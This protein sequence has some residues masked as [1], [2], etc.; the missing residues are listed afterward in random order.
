MQIYKYIN[1]QWIANT[2]SI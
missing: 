2:K 1:F